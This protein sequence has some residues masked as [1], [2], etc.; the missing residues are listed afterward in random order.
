MAGVEEYVRKFESGKIKLMT[1]AITYAEVTSISLSDEVDNRFLKLMQRPNL[2][3]IGADIEVSCKARKLRGYYSSQKEHHNNKTL[4]TPDALH[5]ATAILYQVAEFHTFDASN[6]RSLGLLG[7]NDDVGVDRL[8]I[9]KP[10]A[11]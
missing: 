9:C 11:A 10:G 2:L 7:L 4:S 1:S 5:L 3:V 8:R 6:Q